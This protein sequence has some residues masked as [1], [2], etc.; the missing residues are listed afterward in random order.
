M[1]GAIWKE[2]LLQER[3]LDTRKSGA[4]CVVGAM[5]DHFFDLLNHP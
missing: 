5:R 3:E 1:Q 4:R 2:Q